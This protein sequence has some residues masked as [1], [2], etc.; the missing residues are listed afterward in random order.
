MTT[1]NAKSEQP[2]LTLVRGNR[3]S[4]MEDS[5]LVL[6]CQQKD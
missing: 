3:Y 5:E 2:K 6:L 1:A 4:Q